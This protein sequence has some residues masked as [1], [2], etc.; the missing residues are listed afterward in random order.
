MTLSDLV[1]EI[2]GPEAQALRE[3]IA[4]PT[5]TRKKIATSTLTRV[6]SRG[7]NGISF[8]RRFAHTIVAP[9]LWRG[10]SA[11]SRGLGTEVA[12][13]SVDLTLLV[14]LRSPGAAQS[15]ASWCGGGAL[16]ALYPYMKDDLE[17]QT[18]RLVTLLGK[19]PD[20]TAAD[21]YLEN[22]ER[23]DAF[24]V[25]DQIAGSPAWITASR[26]LAFRLAGITVDTSTLEKLLLYFRR[27]GR[28]TGYPHVMTLGCGVVASLLEDETAPA[29]LQSLER[30]LTLPQEISMHVVGELIQTERVRA[31]LLL[32][33]ASDGV[34][35]E[36]APAI[37]EKRAVVELVMRAGI[38]DLP[39]PFQHQELAVVLVRSVIARA[40][41]DE[42]VRGWLAVVEYAMDTLK[43]RQL[44]KL[45]LGSLLWDVLNQLS[46]ANPRIQPPAY[47][48]MARKLVTNALK[49]RAGQARTTALH[50]VCAYLVQEEWGTALH[51]QRNP[52]EILKEFWAV[53]VGANGIDQVTEALTVLNPNLVRRYLYWCRDQQEND[54]PDLSITAFSRITLEQ[55]LPFVH[56]VTIPLVGLIPIFGAEWAST[57]GSIIRLPASINFFPDSPDVLSSNRN[58]TM[59]VYLAL[60]EAGH[61]TGGSFRY[62][63]KP[64]ALSKLS[65][66]L[67]HEC[68]NFVEDYRIERRLLEMVPDEETDRVLSFGQRYFLWRAKP[69]DPRTMLLHHCL[70]VLWFRGERYRN[71]PDWK[72]EIDRFLQ[73][74]SIPAGDAPNVAVAAAR[75]IRS[76]WSM[77]LNNPIAAVAVAERL[78]RVVID[79]HTPNALALLQ[80]EWLAS[81]GDQTDAGRDEPI[82]VTP[83]MVDALYAAANDN[84]AERINA[85]TEE[86][87]Y[88]MLSSS[89]SDES[90]DAQLD[91]L[92]GM[93]R[94]AAD[95]E[96]A[97]VRK[98]A[99]TH[100][101]KRALK[102]LARGA[103]KKNASRKKTVEPSRRRHIT[104]VRN[105]EKTFREG[106]ITDVQ[107]T[108]VDPEFLKKHERYAMI[109]H[110]I[111]ASLNEMMRVEEKT[112]LQAAEFGTQLDNETVVHLIADYETYASRPVF[113]QQKLSRHDAVVYLGIDIS[114]STAA[115]VDSTETVIDVEKHFAL[116]F[117]D[118]LTAMHITPTVTAFESM[119]S[120]NVYWITQRDAISGLIPGQSNRD[121]D[122]IRY[123]T[124][125]LQTERASR[126]IFFLL[127][128]GL[129]SAAN[130]SGDS[131]IED[132]RQAMIESVQSGI[133]LVYINVDEPGNPYYQSFAQAASA[134]IQC[135]NPKELPDLVPE[136]V[137][138]VVYGL[139]RR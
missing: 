1:R 51:E 59:Y 25:P 103:K 7:Y 18:G 16:G 41:A 123:I 129:P 32:D 77:D 82:P 67:F 46:Q 45:L 86:T 49:A 96:A 79:W 76:M 124:R 127:S 27:V 121:G 83:E 102:R 47:W 63:T 110:R 80:E 19:D 73:D 109:R 60:H 98:E 89:A 15:V 104:P 122:F 131:A 84:P 107:L 75:L 138:Q 72:S 126:K 94:T 135:Q 74:R 56:E 101:F 133:Q 91:F 134:A 50:A 81:E 42:T 38:G 58:I 39:E 9:W 8:L 3:W 52:A 93:K 17:L 22:L 61:L 100:S 106:E 23:L 114:G 137:R 119:T 95:L 35:Q 11:A 116:L 105:D 26:N 69:G 132:T 54:K 62:D 68:F 128:D 70:D 115:N 120:T 6:C 28:Q 99:D 92:D 90:M 34:I 40:R 64:Y 55:A 87:Y 78:Y 66:V 24:S 108:R 65:P 5:T 48:Q 139:G 33:W 20:G 44:T 113:L 71:D 4:G 29:T 85:M 2:D 36:I 118:A 31:R 13:L 112:D 53:A 88:T 117:Y 43:S 136:M 21:R 111:A 57:N 97:K 30:I 12:Q 37:P 130:Y 125:K 14:E 10:A